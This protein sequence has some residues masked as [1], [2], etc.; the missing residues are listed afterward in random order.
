[1]EGQSLKMGEGVDGTEEGGGEKKTACSYN[2]R[3]TMEKRK[4]KGKASRY[5]QQAN[6]RKEKKKATKT[7]DARKILWR[8]KSPTKE[9]R[10]QG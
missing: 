7:G 4:N 10:Q 9:E 3:I 8:G 5:M 2:S 1:M 6:A